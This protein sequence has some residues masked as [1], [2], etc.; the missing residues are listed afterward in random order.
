MR[1]G[2]RCRARPAAL[3]F[4][5]A[6]Q[7]ATLVHAGRVIDGVS[8]TVRTNQTVV[9]DNGK[10]TAIERDSGSPPRAIASSI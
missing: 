5:G 10:I 7:A 2:A 6:T 3:A 4:A 8:D 1:R 9:V